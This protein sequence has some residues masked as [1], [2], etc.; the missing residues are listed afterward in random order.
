M[1]TTDGRVPP[2]NLQAEESLLGA[3]LLSPDAIGAAVELRLEGEDF[4][5]PAHG[6]VYEA[7]V[8]L[9]AQ[10]QPA[11][12]VT[13]SDVLQRAD[14]LEAVGGPSVLISLQA[15]T[16]A[17]G[18]AA[19]YARIVKDHA[20][21]R[22]LIGVAG[23]IAETGYGMP[24]DVAEAVGTAIGLVA[25]LSGSVAEAT[26][27][28]W[29]A[30][31]LGPILRGENPSAEATMLRRTDGQCL[32]YPGK[33]HAFN[34]ESESLKSWLALWACVERIQAG[35][36]VLY[37]DFEAGPVDITGRLVELGLSVAEIE[38]H[39][40]YVQPDEPLDPGARLRTVGMAR[41]IGAT[42]CVID[43]LA[44]ILA[45]SGWDE[46]SPG[47][48]A[49]FYGMLPKPLARTGAAVIN[50]DHLVKDKEKQGNDARGSGHKRAGID[51][52]QFRLDCVKPFAR[53]GE[54]LSRIIVTKDK[55]G[56]VRG[57]AT[58]GKLVGE[59]HMTSRHGGSVV[60]A[61]IRP[62]TSVGPDGLFRPTSLM[63]IVSRWLERAG[64]A[65]T[66][67]WLADNL[68][69]KAKASTVS[70][71][72]DALVA[73]GFVTATQDGRTT[74]YS[75][76]RPYGAGAEPQEPPPINDGYEDD[77]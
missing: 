23:E 30:V 1:P 22:Q 7:A 16:P 13:V 36:N 47:D 62:S 9:W 75:H 73:D 64:K 6:H 26:D 14:L 61:A 48:I 25:D 27:S 68:P 44:E 66:M 32:L 10:D 67:T 19:R 39:F 15:S 3:M 33:I 52:A 21:L 35:E 56:Y 17:I 58:G 31:E 53:D 51:G 54:G 28:S 2:H 70:A 4:Y 8:S 72:V 50:I 77:F 5:R 76:L 20:L 29:D 59:L 34:G 42:L 38:D 63:T 45:L 18:N 55:H 11:D 24:N 60:T 37:V 57:T 43:G 71:A 41:D 74:W 49:T 46:N 65:V 12:P 69:G 40:F